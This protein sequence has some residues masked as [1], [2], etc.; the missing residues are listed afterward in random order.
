VSLLL[1]FTELE[2]D[3]RVALFRQGS[4]EVI[5]TRYTRLFTSDGMFTPDMTALIPRSESNIRV[6]R[7]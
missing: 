7:S 3:D 5:V 2:R 4:F 1:G 6:R